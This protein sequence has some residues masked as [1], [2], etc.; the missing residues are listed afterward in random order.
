MITEQ[1]VQLG[2]SQEDLAP[3]QPIMMGLKNNFRRHRVGGEYDA[4]LQLRVSQRE[5][6]IV[7]YIETSDMKAMGSTHTGERAGEH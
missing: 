6:K 1:K 5:G 4:Q 7:P 3:K 2:I